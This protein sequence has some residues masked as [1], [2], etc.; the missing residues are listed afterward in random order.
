MRMKL[1]RGEN[2]EER[3]NERDRKEISLLSSATT[4]ADAMKKV[5]T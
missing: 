2:K 4:Y 1:H 3:E 5:R